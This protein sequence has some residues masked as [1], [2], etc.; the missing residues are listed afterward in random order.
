MKFN[1][2]KRKQKLKN[3][4]LLYRLRTSER[5]GAAAKPTW[6]PYR[7]WLFSG[8]SRFWTVSEETQLGYEK[9]NEDRR[10]G[11]IPAK[12]NCGHRSQWQW[13][14]SRSGKDSANSSSSSS[15]VYK[16]I[17]GGMM[18]IKGGR[19]GNPRSAVHQHGDVQWIW[20][21]ARYNGGSTSPR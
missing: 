2:T 12:C 4:T 18:E 21:R 6:Q 10:E 13:G 17:A 9:L 15:V 5:G 8:P 7:K 19:A 16:S 3:Q 1:N 14:D 11:L 20:H